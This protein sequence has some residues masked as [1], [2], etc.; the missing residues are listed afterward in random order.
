MPRSMGFI[1]EQYPNH[2]HGKIKDQKNGQ[3][4]YQYRYF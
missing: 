1:A 2:F 4:I 3:K